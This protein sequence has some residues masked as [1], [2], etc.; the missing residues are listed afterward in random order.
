MDLTLRVSQVWWLTP[1][2]SNCR[3]KVSLA[4]KMLVTITVAAKTIR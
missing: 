4:L 2:D 3:F 1:A